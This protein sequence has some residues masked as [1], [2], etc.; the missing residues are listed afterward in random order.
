KPGQ[1]ELADG[2]TLF[3]DEIGDMPATM[4]AK[5]LRVLE[6][7]CITP[8]GSSKSKQVHVRVVA[9][10]NADLRQRVKDGAFREDLYFRL[11]GFVVDVPPLR[12]RRADIP[13]LAEHFLEVFAKDMG[14]AAPSLT[15]GALAALREH[16]FPGNI[17]ELKN[18]IERSLI[19]SGGDAILAEHLHLMP[20]PS[21][22]RP[23]SILPDSTESPDE[24]LPLNL[25]NAENDLIQRALA[26]TG[27]NV[28]EAARRLGVNRTRIYR[29]LGARG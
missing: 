2:G 26:A 3:L 9:A 25:E 23:V 15:A 10:T 5:L 11:A 7:G 20:I 18:V 1:F 21:V 28:A 13:L 16:P 14:L 29:R 8:L 22:G 6:D 27:G 4:Q 17:R 12:D 24:N 19:E